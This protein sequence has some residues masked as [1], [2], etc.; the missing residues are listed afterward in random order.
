MS[1][2]IDSPMTQCQVG[3]NF[4]S[5][6]SLIIL[7]VFLLD[8]LYI[9]VIITILIYPGESATSE[10][11]VL[12]LLLANGDAMEADQVAMLAGASMGARC[13][14]ELARLGLD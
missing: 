10:D 13:P 4:L 5:I 14:D 12:L 11:L 7:L 2:A 8:Y 1:K 6:A 3:P 9:T